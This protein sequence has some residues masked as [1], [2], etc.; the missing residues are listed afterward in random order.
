MARILDF[1]IRVKKTTADRIFKFK[2]AAET[3]DEIIN[4]AL[5]C[6]EKRV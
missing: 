2:K 5:D 6:M 4:R 3:Y 1:P